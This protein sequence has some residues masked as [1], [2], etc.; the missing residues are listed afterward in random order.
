MWLTAAAH[1]VTPGMNGQVPVV[2]PPFSSWTRGVMANCIPAPECLKAGSSIAIQSDVQV[3]SP[4]QETL[5]DPSGSG[6]ANPTKTM[7][8]GSAGATVKAAN[9][10]YVNG[11]LQQQFDFGTHEP[12]NPSS[13]GPD[14]PPDAGFAPQEQPAEPGS[15]AITDPMTQQPEL[16][17]AKS[18]N[19]F[20]GEGGAPRIA[21]GYD[22]NVGGKNGR[23]A[24]KARRRTERGTGIGLLPPPPPPFPASNDSLAV[25]PP[26]PPLSI[27][28]SSRDGATP[29]APLGLSLPPS[30][31]S[32]ASPPPPPPPPSPPLSPPDAA[33]HFA[34]T[35]SGLEMNAE[36]S[37]A[38]L[39]ADL[40][41]G[42]PPNN[43]YGIPNVC[44]ELSEIKSD[45]LGTSE[46]A[47]TIAVEVGGLS[48]YCDFLRGLS[49]GFVDGFLRGVNASVEAFSSG[50]ESHFATA[51]AAGRQQGADAAARRMGLLAA[52]GGDSDGGAA[53]EEQLHER[54][55]L[56]AMQEAE[57]LTFAD[58]PSGTETPLQHS[59]RLLRL[60]T[61]TITL[62]MASAAAPPEPPPPPPS[63]APT[64]PQWLQNQREAS[65]M[66]MYPFEQDAALLRQLSLAPRDQSGWAAPFRAGNGGLEA[67]LPPV[68]YSDVSQ[69]VSGAYLEDS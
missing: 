48:V 28:G 3:R 53:S 33:I 7:F 59:Q 42:A 40:A 12:T 26:P 62:V 45:A 52:Q 24:S 38:L 34:S 64:T 29:S 8:Y 55:R 21:N 17:F 13:Q 31:P 23:S 61:D 51:R 18:T 1:S 63:P 30:P 39:R 9:T 16:A 20:T 37:F 69:P 60:T 35:L 43:A 15:S 36:A 11:A 54:A 2:P 49:A 25:P 50:Y 44:F 65:V 57:T 47:S 6:H 14:Q 32:K 66:T 41:S 67:P 19:D 27:D 4:D 22:G 10:R 46:N 68:V 58:G 5:R 56:Q